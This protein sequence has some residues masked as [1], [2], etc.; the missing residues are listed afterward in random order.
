MDP[1]AVTSS[2]CLLIGP[3]LICP[4]SLIGG[5][6]ANA[7]VIPQISGRRIGY[8]GAAAMCP[9]PVYKPLEM[10]PGGGAAPRP[11]PTNGAPG[12]RREVE[13]RSREGVSRG[14]RRSRAFCRDSSGCQSQRGLAPPPHAIAAPPERLPLISVP[15]ESG[16]LRR[17]GAAPPPPGFPDASL[18]TPTKNAHYNCGRGNV[19]HGGAGWSR[20]LV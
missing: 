19:D 20:S 4:L 10:W 5:N 11:R 13:A 15:S 9:G 12:L 18:L 2:C 3:A 16:R 14:Q 7:A 17:R 8:P 6:R 1:L